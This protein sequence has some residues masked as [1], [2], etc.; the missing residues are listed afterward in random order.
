MNIGIKRYFLWAVPL[1]LLS[2]CA[3]DNYDPPHSMLSGKIVYN[4]KPIHVASQRVTFN[5]FQTGFK[6][7]VPITVQVAPDGSYHALLFDG[8]YQ[9]IFPR[10]QGPFIQN[11]KKIH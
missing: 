8:N 1:L 3:Y 9:I 2:S 11:T 7:R 6:R 10:G 4:G 5:L